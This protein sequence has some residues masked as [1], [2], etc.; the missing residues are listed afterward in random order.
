MEPLQHIILSTVNYPPVAKFTGPDGDDT[1]NYAT[2]AIQ[3]RQ[4]FKYVRPELCPQ[5][6]VPTYLPITHLAN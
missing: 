6:C 1:R 5:S 4:T 3:N 2:N